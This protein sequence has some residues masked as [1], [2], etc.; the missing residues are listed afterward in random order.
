MFS[1]LRR[2]ASSSSAAPLLLSALTAATV[3][4]SLDSKNLGACAGGTPQRKETVVEEGLTTKKFYFY[5]TPAAS[6]ISTKRTSIYTLPSSLTLS[7]DVT[8]LLGLPLSSLSIGKYADGETSVKVED[9]CRGKDVFVVCSTVDDDSLMECL[10]T[11]STL[12]RASAKSI[13][14]I[15]P[16]YG[17]SRSD[18]KKSPRTPIAAADIALM[19]G[20]MGLDS[21][22]CM[23]LHNDSLRGFFE[24][25]IPVDHLQ[26]VPVAAAWFHEQ[27]D[28][29]DICVVA[30]HEGQ[31]ARAADFRKRL[32]KLSGVDVPMAFVSKSRSHHGTRE[33]EYEPIL[34][35]DVTGKT[36]IIVDDIISSGQTMLKVNELLH[37]AGCKK[38][39]GYAT[40]GLFSTPDVLENFQKSSMEYVLVTN[41]IY[42]K[43]GSLPEKVKQLSVAPL[44]AEAV[45]RTVGKRSVS[46]IL[47]EEEEE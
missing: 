45:A 35:G 17:Y 13:C 47:N 23:D 22:I 14:C 7:R 15:I 26:P 3:G 38:S 36:V 41:T 43:P 1:S 5:N 10:L 8:S 37:E 27:L 40:H 28:M 25:G 4:Y 39:Y 34:V 31:V 29:K 30:P 6:S 21:A 18:Q 44:V 19:F 33:G 20:T 42:Q 46:G 16:Y 12:R 9:G 11:I 32:Q 2:A 24:S